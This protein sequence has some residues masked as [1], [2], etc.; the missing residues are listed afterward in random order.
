MYEP[1]LDPPDEGFYIDG[2]V[3]CGCCGYTIP[4]LA[5]CYDIDGTY[6][7]EDCI[8]QARTLAP[9]KGEVDE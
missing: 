3:R 8:E 7:C 2:A 4:A 9:F 6:Y 5:T 1:R